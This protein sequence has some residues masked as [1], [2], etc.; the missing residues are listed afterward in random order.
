MFIELEV[1]KTIQEKLAPYKELLNEFADKIE[2]L[3]RIP[4]T[5]E[6][7]KYSELK[8]N[9]GSANKAVT[10]C[11]ELF[12]N[13]NYNKIVKNKKNDILV[14]LAL[15]N[16]KGKLKQK[17]INE[18]LLNEIV[19]HFKN[20]S[21]ALILASAQLIK[22]RD[23]SKIDLACSQ[24]KYGKILPDSLYIHTDYINELHPILKLFVGCAT[25]FAGILSDATLFK[26]NRK[27]RKVSFLY[28]ENFDKDPHPKLLH[29]IV[30]DL[31]YFTIKDWDQSTKNPPI[32]HRKE[33][34]VGKDYPN[35]NKFS[36]L[37]KQEEKAGLFNTGRFT[38]REKHWNELLSSMKLHIKGHKLYKF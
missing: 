2:E 38:G 8:L 26:I 37:T 25:Q 11:E 5:E 14:Y 1:Y 23:H 22:L 32:L 28:Y 20:F 7:I 15:S 29:S 36:K 13:F 6:F 33:T 19:Y 4:N 35:Y 31:N 21:N 30:V 3:G 18:D 10:Y 17:S 24:S 9:I 34:F 27:K 12:D 16:L